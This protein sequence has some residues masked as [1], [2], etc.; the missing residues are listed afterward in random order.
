MTTIRTIEGFVSGLEVH[1]TDVDRLD[2][3]ADRGGRTR[4]EKEG[5]EVEGVKDVVH[6]L[7]EGLRA[8]LEGFGGFATELGMDAQEIAV[9]TET[10]GVGGDKLDTEEVVEEEVAAAAAVGKTGREERLKGLERREM[11]QLGA[12]GGSGERGQR[13][14]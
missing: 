1:W 5:E 3:H 13:G 14:R 12:G 11:E 9:A 2:R 7:R 8:L 6:C 10:A 4:Q